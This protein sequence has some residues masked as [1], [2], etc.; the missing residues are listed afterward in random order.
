MRATYHLRRIS[1]KGA[2][3]VFLEGVGGARTDDSDSEVSNGNIDQS[4]SPC[5]SSRIQQR[6]MMQ[7]IRSNRF[8]AQ[9][10]TSNV[11]SRAKGKAPRHFAGAETEGSKTA[12]ENL[13]CV[14][15]FS[16]S[17]RLTATIRKL[18]LRAV[19][20]DRGS[21]SGTCS[22]ARNKRHRD[23][24]DAGFIMNWVLHLWNRYLNKHNNALLQ[25]CNMLTWGFWL[26]GL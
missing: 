13:L 20:I 5:K 11:E 22:S 12:F 21:S 17:G 16:G 8:R 15:F 2:A 26:V 18:G 1:Q 10:S 4:F 7:M 25:L 14:E 3:K 24:E 6:G 9:P 23:L 19:A